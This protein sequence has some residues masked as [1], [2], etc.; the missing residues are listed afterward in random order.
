MKLDYPVWFVP[1]YP[2]GAILHGKELDFAQ[3]R[4]IRAS[5]AVD[6]GKQGLLNPIIVWNHEPERF[7]HYCMQGQNRLAALKILNWKYV[8]VIATGKCMVGEKTALDWEAIQTYFLDGIVNV[9]SDGA[10]NLKETQRPDDYVYP[11]GTRKARYL[12]EDYWVPRN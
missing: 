8:P 9:R 12:H 11:K 7:D 2:I 6:I 1:H 10:I 4:I 3:Q 5:L